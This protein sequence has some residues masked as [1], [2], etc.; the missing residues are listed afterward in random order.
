MR[1]LSRTPAVRRGE[2]NTIK[3]ME[4]MHEVSQPESGV[5]PSL[6]TALF[7]CG[8][9]RE[10]ESAEAY[11]THMALQMCWTAT[12]VKKRRTQKTGAVENAGATAVSDGTVTVDFKVDGDWLC[13]E[14]SYHH[15]I[16]LA[17]RIAWAVDKAQRTFSSETNARHEPTGE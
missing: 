12:E 7:V 4:P 3:S 15:A 14:I 17:N 11:G 5:S 2:R 16:D 9:G 8:C 1:L 6:S 10:F 13:F